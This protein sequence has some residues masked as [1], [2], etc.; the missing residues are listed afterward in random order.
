MADMFGRVSKTRE[1][2]QNTEQNILAESE[3]CKE[4]SKEHDEELAAVQELRDLIEETSKSHKQYDHDLDIL[5]KQL[6][7]SMHDVEKCLQQGKLVTML[8]VKG[9]IKSRCVATVCP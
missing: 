1:R 6:K 8:E 5:K 7:A 4:L 2:I 3:I 9:E